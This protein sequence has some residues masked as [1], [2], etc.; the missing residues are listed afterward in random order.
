M[1]DKAAAFWPVQ[2]ANLWREYGWDINRNVNK[3][4]EFSKSWMVFE[5]LMVEGYDVI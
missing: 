1:Q 5:V 2:D 4:A 3:R